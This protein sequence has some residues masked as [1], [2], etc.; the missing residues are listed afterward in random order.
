MQESIFDYKEE[1]VR[2]IKGGRMNK[3]YDFIDYIRDEA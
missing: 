1:V 3:R 2:R